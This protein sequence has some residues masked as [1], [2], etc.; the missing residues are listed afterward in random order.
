MGIYTSIKLPQITDEKLDDRKERQQILNYLGLLDEKLRYMFQNIDID[1]NLSED[2]KNYLFEQG[3]A[4]LNVVKD[5]E[6]NFSL[7]RQEVDN[8]TAQVETAQGDIAQL[9][10]T[11][12]GLT[13][14]VSSA[15][16]KIS[17]LEQTANG[18][19][20]RVST[21]EDGVETNKSAIAQTAG[22]I[23]S[24]VSSVSTL[25]GKV[26]TNESAITQTA[27]VID[28]MVTTS[29]GANGQ[30]K[31]SLTEEMADEISSKIEISADKI[32]LEGYVTFYDLKTN[33][34]TEINGDYICTGQINAEFIGLGGLMEIHEELTDAYT[35]VG[36][37][38]GYLTGNDGVNGATSGVALMDE[39]KCRYFVATT[40]AARVSAFENKKQG[41]ASNAFIVAH[42][43]I[44]ATEEISVSSDRRLKENISYD[45]DRYEEFYEKLKPSYFKYQDG[46]SGRY[47]IGFIAQEVEDAIIGSGI[48]TQ[49]FAGLVHHK[50]GDEV[51]SEYADQYGL[52][53]GEFI[54]LNT[55][56]IQKLMARVSELE[57]K[58][59]ALS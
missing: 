26:S 34:T 12:K 8:I 23:Q 15:E 48:T 33:G 10:M 14:S 7:F 24:V 46:S 41:A 29:K 30:I 49:D 31:I 53:Y 13:S 4:V 58:L 56:M 22:Q 42:D 35:D 55:H 40:S 5:A 37:Y 2:S 36:G 9:Q 3:E 39:H 17:T 52:R 32:D 1:E 44:S 6:G 38:I 28:L 57:S 45:L 19:A 16:G 21:V 43:Y 20:T 18:I 47:H 51:G 50:E 27:E 59:E 11:A 54:A 25:N